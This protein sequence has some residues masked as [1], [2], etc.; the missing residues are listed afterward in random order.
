MNTC[1]RRFAR[2][3]RLLAAVAAL[4]PVLAPPRARAG[5]DNTS[6]GIGALQINTGSF[7]TADGFDA[8]FHNTNATYDTAVGFNALFSNI[9]GVENTAAGAGALQSNT[10]GVQNT[11]G[12]VNALARNTT[13][14]QNTADGNRAPRAQHQC[15]RQHGGRFRGALQQHAWLVQRGRWGLRALRQRGRRE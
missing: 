12:G 6:T 8:L 15:P 14:N 11:A 4:W 10:T 9:T 2:Y 13:G 3:G 1:P 7:D 5:T